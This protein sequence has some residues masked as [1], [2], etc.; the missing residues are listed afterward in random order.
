MAIFENRPTNPT[1]PIT[2][3]QDL[4]KWTVQAIDTE[5]RLDSMGNRRTMIN[6]TPPLPVSNFRT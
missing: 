1:V 3:Q 5:I 6:S 2:I 4:F